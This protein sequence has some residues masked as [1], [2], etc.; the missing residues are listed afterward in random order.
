MEQDR[1]IIV[2]FDVLRHISAKSLERGTTEDVL[3]RTL[4]KIGLTKDEAGEVINQARDELRKKGNA[5]R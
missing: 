4:M 1:D 3:E 2:D 5:G